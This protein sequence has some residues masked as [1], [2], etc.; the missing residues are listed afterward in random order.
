MYFRGIEQALINCIIINLLPLLRKDGV[1]K[2]KGGNSLLVTD[3]S[4]STFNPSSSP[5]LHFAA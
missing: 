3:T 4:Q 2:L 5:L 1:Y